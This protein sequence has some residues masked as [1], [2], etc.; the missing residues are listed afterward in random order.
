MEEDI[1]RYKEYIKD[2]NNCPSSYAKE[3]IKNWKDG[4]KLRRKYIDND[5]QEIKSLKWVLG[6]R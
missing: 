5:K 4:I 6:I 3:R 2:E 1:N